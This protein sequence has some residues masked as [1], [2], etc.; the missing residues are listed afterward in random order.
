MRWKKNNLSYMAALSL[1]LSLQACSSM[2][3]WSETEERL[4]GERVSILT[5][6]TSQEAM[7][8][9]KFI[10]KD[11][12]LPTAQTSENWPHAGGS[13]THRLNHFSGGTNLQLAWEANI[14]SSSERSIKYI[15]TP[16][17]ANNRLFVMNI[18]GEV[19]ALSTNGQVVW[20]TNIFNDT[21]DYSIGGGLSYDNGTIYVSS[22]L[23]E[24][25]ALSAETGEIQWRQKFDSPFRG[26]PTVHD[27]KVYAVTIDNET[28]VVDAKTGNLV[29]NH[30]GLGEMTNVIGGSAPVIANEMVLV[31]HSSGELCAYW[32]NNGEL[33]WVGNL[34]KIRAGD[35]FGSLSDI[36]ALPVVDNNQVI[37]A[38]HMNMF[39]SIDLGS[40]L[41][42]W[43][44]PIGTSQTPVVANEVIF[45]V[46]SKSKLYAISKSTGK[47]FWQQELQSHESDSE[48]SKRI[49]WYGP[50]LVDKKLMLV[51]SLGEVIVV[52]SSNGQIINRTEINDTVSQAPIYVNGTYYF[53]GNSG[54]IMAYKAQ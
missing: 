54:K 52:D 41:T 37:A 15:S 44:L 39:A 8:E 31:P 14:G 13:I 1:L 23:G 43:S 25:L 17:F 18:N 50:L 48:A 35:Q 51:N 11:F 28:I 21:D 36:V 6:D 10:K 3:F 46:S 16:V 33:M 24:I 49:V 47:F 45:T 53:V 29:W 30:Q 32:A 34:A 9:K 27:D 19:N 4:P 2:S 20:K 26:F 12:Q 42:V 40:G 38:N 7:S 5:S 22:P